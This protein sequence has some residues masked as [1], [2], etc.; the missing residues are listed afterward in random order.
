[1][2][3]FRTTERESTTIGEVAKHVAPWGVFAGCGNCEFVIFVMVYPSHP[4]HCPMCGRSL[5]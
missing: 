3:A 2:N 4:K 1:M 5:R